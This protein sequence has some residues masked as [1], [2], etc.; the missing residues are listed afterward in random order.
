MI[1][2]LTKEN[3]NIINNSFL[4]KDEIIHEFENNPFAKILIYLDNDEIIGYLYYSDIYDRIEINQIEINFIHRNCGKGTKLLEFLIETVDKSITL[5][6]NKE[7]IP[8][9]KLYKKFNFEEVAIRPGYYNGVDG[10]LM[11]RKK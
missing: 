1:K 6:V 3:I 11:E 5:E 4:N 2:E 7:N 10:I 9:I 8:A